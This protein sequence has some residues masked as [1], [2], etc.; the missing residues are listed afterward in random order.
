MKKVVL[1]L[2]LLA[3][4][5]SGARAEKINV[6]SLL[7]RLPALKEDSNKVKLLCAIGEAYSKTDPDA[8][9][10]YGDQAKALAGT[11]GWE[12]GAADAE[13][14][15]AE[16]YLSKAD[17]P[18]A[19]DC[20]QKALRLYKAADQNDPA[21]RDR[22]YL[23][24]YKL[25]LV[26]FRI[27]DYPGALS[28]ALEAL[29][30]YE[31][32]GNKKGIADASNIIANAHTYSGNA[33]KG[34]EYYYK[35]LQMSTEIGDKNG[36]AAVVSNIGDVYI[37]QG[38]FDSGIAWVQRAF[39]MNEASGNYH[40]QAINLF[41]IANAYLL[42][43]ML[44]QSLD[45]SFRSL[46]I[47]E[48]HDKTTIPWN[49]AMISGCYLHMAIDSPGKIPAGSRIPGTRATHL[50]Q[51]ILYGNKA[52]K[53]DIEAGD[54]QGLKDDYHTLFSAQRLAG[55]NKAAIES[56][57]QY[58]A[59]KDSIYNIENNTKM[60]EME[61]QRE[62]VLKEKQIEL[63]KLAVV[64]KRNERGFYLGGIGGLLVIVGIMFRN[65][66]I[67]KRGNELQLI[68]NRQLTI[69]KQKS[70]DLLLNILP[71]EVAEELKEKGVAEA[72]LFD[73]VTVLFTDFVDFTAA[74]QRMTAKELVGELHA[75]F[76]AF[77]DIL[78]KY[79]I[80]KIKTIGDAYLAVSGV[81]VPVPGH[82]Q[83]VL[84][85]AVDIL[86]FMT[87]RKKALG[88]KTFGIRIGIHSG[89][90]VA[91]IVGV[92]K[93]AYDIWGDTVNTASRMEQSSMPGKIN[94]S[95]TTYDLVKD[96][97]SCT[98]RGEIDVKGK[99]VMKMYYVE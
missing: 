59:I 32:T 42:Q 23:V 99:G 70:E 19:L 53:I 48:A 92:K 94:I 10:R 72:R 61:T 11:T 81:P 65:Y 73:Q 9:I 39:Q 36:M 29:K 14:V 57:E 31:S 83:H 95:Q 87:E 47:A 90:V 82:A 89:S 24:H 27:G 35:S 69:E 2:F 63:D 45:Y 93:F 6:D 75:C 30:Y 16:N 76:H 40:Y 74:G 88:D 50:A 79:E 46:K 68:S 66:K 21:V 54:L 64:K 17:Y 3:A 98:Y 28:N 71:A 22:E 58:T 67:Q 26:L 7:R 38:K 8:G 85:A 80:E 78:N 13:C 41:T 51:C 33:G 15:L 44:S 91:G 84:A 60:S 18:K 37:K 77:D 25:G 34:L 49:Y 96:S 52:I 5:K 20:A 1:S 62:V 12:R 4:L 43:A 86:H 55:D 97:F 56:Y